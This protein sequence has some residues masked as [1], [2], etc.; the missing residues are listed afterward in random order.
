MIDKSSFLWYSVLFTM[1]LQVSSKRLNNYLIG[2]LRLHQRFAAQ[3][4]NKISR[5]GHTPLAQFRA[6]GM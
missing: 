3:T 5:R 2:D 6:M 4:S 1:K